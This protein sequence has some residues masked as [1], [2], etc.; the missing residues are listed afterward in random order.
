[1]GGSKLRCW[2]EE[3]VGHRCPPS[4]KF[5]NLDSCRLRG[6]AWPSQPEVARTDPGR[7]LEGGTRRLRGGEGSKAR[8][9]TCCAHQGASGTGGHL[10]AVLAAVPAQ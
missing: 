2:A 6:P 8:G 5:G 1:M 4:T 3:A 10:R 7:Q 9:W